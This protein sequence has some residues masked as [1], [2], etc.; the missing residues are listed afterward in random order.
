MQDVTEQLK[1][2]SGPVD[3]R[4]IQKDCLDFLAN[5]EGQKFDL[6]YLDPP[7]FLNREFKLEA[8]SDKAKFQG[9]WTEQDIH[10]FAE[11][12]VG[13]SGPQ[14]LVNYL[15]WLL[16]RIIEIH[17]HLAETG[18]IYLHIGTREAPYVSLLLDRVFGF[19]NWRSTITW[20][21]SHPH[22]NMTKA[23]GN[24]ADF[25]YY[26]SK[27]SEFTFNLQYTPHD[28]KYL[29]NSF[30]NKDEKGNYALAPIIQERSRQGHFYEFNGVTPP[31]GWRVKE[32]ELKRL[33]DLGYIHWGTNRPYKKVYRE[34]TQGA[35]MQNI[36][37][38]I[39]NITRTD[40]DKRHY[41]TQKPLKLL[42]RVIALSSNEGDLVY[43]PFCGS[44]T[45]LVAAAKLGREYLGT[46]ISSDAIEVAAGRLAI[47]KKEQEE[48][49][50]NLLF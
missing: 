50:S 14:N 44:G 18:S 24:V 5:Y 10:K 31:N 30:N 48:Q 27:S 45:T 8:T 6:V 29:A 38:D 7:F 21:R 26:Y 2:N 47:L 4:L 39:Y 22:N 17:R 28:E 46:D 19:N 40:I 42:E 41:P 11:E 16:I 9:G 33:S 12:I 15:S 13:A 37:T 43:D 1:P 36:W 49:S 20:Q 32:S 3:E 23:L 25:I 35:L 34:E